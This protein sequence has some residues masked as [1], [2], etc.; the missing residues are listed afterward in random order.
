M[1]YSYCFRSFL[2]LCH[3]LEIVFTYFFSISLKSRSNSEPNIFFISGNSAHLPPQDIHATEPLNELLPLGIIQLFPKVSGGRIPGIS[4][5]RS[6]ERGFNE[7]T[8][9][10]KSVQV[11]QAGEPLAG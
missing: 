7:I 4:I 1:E 2:K 11:A 5:D 8:N 10:G 6:I 3:H 9:Y